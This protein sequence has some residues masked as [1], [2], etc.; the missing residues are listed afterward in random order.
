M[1]YDNNLDMT[2]EPKSTPT[3]TEY[4]TA[5]DR[6]FRKLYESVVKALR[7]TAVDLSNIDNRLIIIGRRHQYATINMTHEAVGYFVVRL[8]RE[9]QNL[10][11]KNSWQRRFINRLRSTKSWRAPAVLSHNFCIDAYHDMKVGDCMDRLNTVLNNAL[12]ATGNLTASIDN[13][14][15]DD[16]SLT[17]ED[18]IASLKQAVIADSNRLK[19]NADACDRK[20][21]ESVENLVDVMDFMAKGVEQ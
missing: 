19:F 7:L 3:S 8:G 17:V 13:I 10:Y 11:D 21:K 1:G 2:F 14:G 15:E 16:D 20:A 12:R 5:Q 4:D 18:R 9:Y 6:F